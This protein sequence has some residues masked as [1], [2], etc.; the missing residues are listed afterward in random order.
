MSQFP[1]SSDASLL[2]RD[3]RGRYR[4]RLCENPASTGM[5]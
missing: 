3:G 5:I 1:L 4:P 2:V